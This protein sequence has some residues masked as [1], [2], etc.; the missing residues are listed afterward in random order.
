MSWWQYMAA[1]QRNLNIYA[2]GIGTIQSYVPPG[3]L[4]INVKSYSTDA[5]PSD[6][7]TNNVKKLYQIRLLNCNTT[8]MSAGPVPLREESCY[9]AAAATYMPSGPV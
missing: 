6:M 5:R 1:V 8:Y 9:V 7:P 4:K 3:P 2:F